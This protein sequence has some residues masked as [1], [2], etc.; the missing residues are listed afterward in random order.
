MATSRSQ[1][2]FCHD[3]NRPICRCGDFHYNA[4]HLTLD[5]APAIGSQQVKYNNSS[6]ITQGDCA[7]PS[8]SVESHPEKLKL[9]NWD[10][11]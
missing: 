10:S 6:K 11:L 5:G 3:I 9:K 7:R 2:L 8:S 4:P 1:I